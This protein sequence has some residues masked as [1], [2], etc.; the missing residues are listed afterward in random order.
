MA[1]AGQATP[2]ENSIVQFV[3]QDAPESGENAC[4][5]VGL[6]PGFAFQM[7]RTLM[8]DPFRESLAKNIPVVLLNLP[9]TGVSS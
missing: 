9:T 6:P 8:A 7:K 5:Q 4:S 1:S 2:R 3:S